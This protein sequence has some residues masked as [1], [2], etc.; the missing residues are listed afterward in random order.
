M[1]DSVPTDKIA[2]NARVARIGVSS[3]RSIF[4][5]VVTT[6]KEQ[7]KGQRVHN[8]RFVLPSSSHGGRR[9]EPLAELELHGLAEAAAST[10]RGATGDILLIPEMPSPLG[11]PDFV[12]LAGGWEWLRS[13]RAVGIEPILG[14]SECLV[15][16]ALHSKQS[17]APETIARRIGWGLFELEPVLTRLE[18]ANAIRCTP[19]GAVTLNQALVPSGSLTALEAKVKDWQK[20]VL[21]G[22]TYRTW[23]NNYVVVLGEVGAVAE[24][25]A[26]QDVSRDGDGLYSAAGWIVHPK[27]RNPALA[28]RIRGFEYL[29]AAI[30]GSDP[31]F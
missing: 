30:A 13:R 17:L 31:T 8:I 9:F 4:N 7:S 26:R 19:R 16:A 15:L 5:C 21:Q 12:A 6:Q 25:R 11:L 14:E 3:L 20:A 18:R 1:P 28:K 2:M 23:A 22:R 29:Y 27:A 10:L 24:S